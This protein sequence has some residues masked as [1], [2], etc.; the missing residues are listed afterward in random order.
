MDEELELELELAVAVDRCRVV[1]QVSEWYSGLEG[2]EC[3]A[4][5]LMVGRVPS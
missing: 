2:S 4:G 3:R 1:D 5:G